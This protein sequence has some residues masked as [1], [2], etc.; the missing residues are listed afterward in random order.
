[1]RDL[2]LGRPIRDVDLVVEGDATRL[3]RRLAERLRAEVR[4][5]ERFGTATVLPPEGGA[6]DLAATRREAYAR[7]GALPDVRLGVPVEEDLARRDFT[8]N[9]IALEL[10]PTRT[11]ID[12]FEGT[13]DLRRG[14]IR[15]LHARSF[16]DDPTRIF[17]AVRYAH[18]L[19]FR[20]A[21]A[22]R[23]RI[24]EA[25]AAGALDRISADRLR[26]EL[27]LLL[28]EPRPSGA[29]RR[30]DALGVSRAIHPALERRPGASR[31][32]RRAEGL[33]TA[34]PRGA[35]WLA[36]LLAWLGPTTAGEAAGVAARL[37][38]S[39]DSG[40]RVS[41][42]P[43]V[44]AALPR[45]IA[46]RP[47]SEI[48]LV[49]SRLSPDEVLALAA[50]LPRRDAEALR[51]GAAP[52]SGARLSIGGRDL[53]AAGVPP[54]PAVGRALQRTRAA[55]EDGRIAAGDQLE[56]ALRAAREAER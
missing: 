25:L 3:A 11:R 16:L 45:G 2:I 42:W 6:L 28:A 55:L 27:A 33:A 13:A 46:R 26:R 8:I 51:E 4:V 48:R 30:L 39:G 15:E 54:G 56:F 18:R 31:R 38:L 49:A 44:L 37:G 47:P 36:F 43:G 12:P 32:L 23:R 34:S 7:P 5:H 24:R 19:G 40:R 17:R 50:L 20:I 22:T 9:A 14:R 41:G 52:I 53:L 21:P 29:V 1:M 10:G 35:G